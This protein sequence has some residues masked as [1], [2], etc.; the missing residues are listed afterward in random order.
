MGFDN[1]S[2]AINGQQNNVNR[3][4]EDYNLFD[5]LRKEGRSLQDIVKQAEEAEALR[6][7]MDE[8]GRTKP[9]MD[10]AVFSLME[11]YVRDDPEVAAARNRLLD[12]RNTIIS[13]FCMKDNR[14]RG[15]FESYR[16]TVQERY[17]RAREGI[18]QTGSPEAPDTSEQYE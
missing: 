6:K 8:M 14:Y 4:L 18:A 2:L 16:N 9:R 13:E 1:I 15:E 5:R 3:D 11:E 7:Q 17:V 10:A 12:M